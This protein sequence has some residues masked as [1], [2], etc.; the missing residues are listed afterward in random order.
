MKSFET[1][2]ID[3]DNNLVA[4]MKKNIR[5]YFKNVRSSDNRVPLRTIKKLLDRTYGYRFNFN[6]IVFDGG[7]SYRDY[8]TRVESD[9]GVREY[10]SGKN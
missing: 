7:S 3:L 4:D 6:V 5:K 10:T 2:L 8:I 1:T 9:W